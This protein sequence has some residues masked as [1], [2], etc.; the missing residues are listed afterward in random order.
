MKA[1]KLA[2]KFIG[3]GLLGAIAV[4]VPMVP[5]I[6]GFNGQISLVE[7]ERTGVAVHKE[8]RLVLQDT[9]RHRGAT[10]SWLLGQA[11]F[12]ERAD[13]A[14]AGVDA[15]IANA[16]AVI[17][18]S[19]T[20]IGALPQ[21]QDFKANWQSLKGEYSG[22]APLENT[23]RHTALIVQLMGLMDRVADQSELVLDP[24]ALT[25]FAMDLAILQ[26]PAV[27]ERMGQ[28]RALGSLILSGKVL[29]Q[30]QRDALIDG[31]SEVSLRQRQILA[32][33]DKIVAEDPTAREA[34]AGVFAEAKGGVEAFVTNVQRNIL[35]AETLSYNPARYFDET[36]QGIN[37]LFKL[38]DSSARYLDQS[39]VQR[40]ERIRS[41]RLMVLAIAFAL[42][43]LVAVVGFVILR[44][45]NRS[46]LDVADALDQIAGG[47]LDIVLN[48]CSK[49]EIGHMVD[50]LA[51]MQ[52]QLRNR[53][54]AEHEAANATLRIKVALDVSSNNVM[55]AD[56]DGRIIYCNAAAQAMMRAA[57]NDIRKQLPDFRADAILGSN[58]DRYHKAPGHQRNLL[59]GLKGSHRAALNIGGRHFNLVASPIVN[60][61]GERQGTVLEWLDRT[62][63]VLVEQEVEGIIQAAVAG[64]FSKRLDS[65][66]MNGFF[67]QLA[68]GIN[69]LL[70]ANTRAL[71]D[72]G[73]MFARL[74]QGDLTQKI[75]G[76]YRG[77]L[78]TLK[79]DANATV[80]KL[81][82]IVSSI[83]VATDAITNAA[84]EIASGNQDLSGRTE[85]QA[86]S[87]EETASSM[88]Q[89]TGTVKQNADNARQANELAGNAQQVA[90][91]G[92]EVVA[93]VVDTMSAIHQSSNKIADIIGVIDGIAF[94]TNILA[95]NAAVEAARAGEQGR[96]FAV[97]ATE[98]R[99][100]AQRSAAAAKEIKGLIS[101][102]VDKVEAGNRL[103][104][105][106]GRTMEEVVGSIK[107]VARIMSEIS[108]ASREQTAG[109][110]Q[111][112]QAVS[113]MD[114]VTQQNAALV[115]QAAA[116][117]ESL[118]EQANS[119]AQAV[120]VFV[121][122]QQAGV[123][124]RPAASTRVRASRT[125]S[126]P[127]LPHREPVRL[128]A[129]AVMA[130]T[131]AARGDDEDE[132]AEF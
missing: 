25:Y 16:D 113:Q 80:D 68:E 22:L 128:G 111:V 91:K 50:R 4:A 44:R 112:S 37:A 130:K 3:L 62:L 7:K 120:A 48:H 86:S 88:E 27:T 97:V 73:A 60:E 104:D 92:G 69:N 65:T 85:E 74:A 5:L 101:D 11:E 125:P 93:Q 94:Q 76:D 47:R 95:L 33:A 83:K 127:A 21:W 14:R 30:D 105:Q 29:A 100:L 72:V 116:A 32:D 98:V 110:E 61:R 55:V 2:N 108:D 131:P 38:Y 46:V 39:L 28:A 119:L 40:G 24:E 99:N 19:A 6:N 23:K 10:T 107:R 66:R 90:V 63:E 109:I 77:M 75:D 12:K 114:E 34:L 115:E 9:Q 20:G 45:V 117:A 71:E 132:W 87:L 57:E 122:N 8:L 31:F 121:L 42:I 49:D 1:E 53:L 59:A 89:L 96:G 51:E 67:K 58:F 123:P 15:A 41:H 70:E 129:Q 36:T 79:S 78:G 56:P 118:E 81:E 26:V 64:D 103:V 52:T 13:G 35:Q 106:A 84:Q 54:D 102:S 126:R 43:A 82:Q 17:A 18:A 124:L